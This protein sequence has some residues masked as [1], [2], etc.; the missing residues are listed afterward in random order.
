MKDSQ[1][2]MLIAWL[3]ILLGVPRTSVYAVIAGV[4]ILLS[5]A[6]HPSERKVRR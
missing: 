4:F 5:I 3:I 2:Y 6:S 1:Y